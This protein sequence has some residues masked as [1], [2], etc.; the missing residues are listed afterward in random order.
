MVGTTPHV[1]AA[2]KADTGRD[3]PRTM[4]LP[5]AFGA[6][7]DDNPW[8]QWFQWTLV[9]VDGACNKAETQGATK[10]R[11]NVRIGPIPGGMQIP[12]VSLGQPA[13]YPPYSFGV[14]GFNLICSYYYNTYWQPVL[15]DTFWMEIGRMGNRSL[16]EWNMPDVFMTAGYT[17]NNFFHYLAGGVQGLAYFTYSQRTDSVWPEIGRL[18]KVVHR[19]GPV[20]ARAG[21]RPAGHRH[22][23]FLHQQLL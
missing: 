1:L 22:A 5:P 3:P 15:T 20:Q 17:R 9:H 11:P 13:Q 21:P 4:E 6:I 2:F 12:L 19:I 16:P 14:N 18:G 10:T 23:Q 8:L 7:P